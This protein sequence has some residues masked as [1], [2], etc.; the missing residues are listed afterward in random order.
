M[1][2][3]E[4]QEPLITSLAMLFPFLHLSLPPPPGGAFLVFY[5][6]NIAKCPLVC[7]NYH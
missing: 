1:G 3:E 2:V 7:P 5:I 6:I 4:Q